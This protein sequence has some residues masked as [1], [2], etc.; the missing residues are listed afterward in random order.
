MVQTNGR[1]DGAALWLAGAVRTLQKR[2]EMLEAKN[3][4]KIPAD[5][6]HKSDINVATENTNP[7]EQVPRHKGVYDWKYDKVRVRRPR[8][9]A[10]WTAQSLP[11]KDR[12]R[13]PFSVPALD[14]PV[15][16]APVDECVTSAP[17]TEFVTQ[18]AAILAATAVPVTALSDLLEPPVPVEYANYE[19]TIE[20]LSK[21][22]EET[23]SVVKDEYSEYFDKP[24]PATLEDYISWLDTGPAPD[25]KKYFISM[26]RSQEVR[27]AARTIQWGRR[28]MHKKI[29]LRAD[30]EK[31]L[32]KKLGEVRRRFV[33]KLP[34]GDSVK[35]T[36]SFKDIQSTLKDIEKEWRMLFTEELRH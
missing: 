29:E 5:T 27:Y 28:W 7:K 4:S 22:M 36:E 31:S 32:Q 35:K 19:G 9:A 33:E 23:L 18:P 1:I 2:V 30:A 21:A 13:A 34:V 25:K 15:T 24:T 10:E 14:V 11:M 20:E 3:S 17:T 12:G 8:R 16:T 6:R 26:T